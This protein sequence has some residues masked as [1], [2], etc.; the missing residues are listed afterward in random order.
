[1]IIDANNVKTTVVTTIT[2]QLFKRMNTMT[3]ST[4]TSPEE[5]NGPTD[6]LHALHRDERELRVLAVILSLAGGLV[7]SFLLGVGIFI[8]WHWRAYRARQLKRK[9]NKD[10]KRKLSCTSTLSTT[11]STTSN[12]VYTVQHS[13][14]TISENSLPSPTLNMSFS[15]SL[16]SSSSSYSNNHQQ[17]HH[18][19]YQQSPLQSVQ[20]YDN[21]HIS[22]SSSFS[23]SLPIPEASQLASISSSTA[24]PNRESIDNLEPNISDIDEKKQLSKAIIVPLM[25]PSTLLHPSSSSSS[26]VAPPIPSAPTA[27]ECLSMNESSSIDQIDI[28]PPAYSPK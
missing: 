6:M 7:L 10:D 1:M 14:S 18:H 23:S 22:T 21:P 19:T 8:Y 12:N 24:T 13:F 3:S 11:S 27:K 4:I 16:S 2:K 20:H 25:P 17:H 28:P 26:T 15:S 5:T 9:K